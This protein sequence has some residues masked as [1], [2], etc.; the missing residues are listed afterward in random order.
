MK[1]RA[2]PE[3]YHRAIV[4]IWAILTAPRRAPGTLSS[5]CKLH[6][7]STT[8]PAALRRSGLISGSRND[9]RWMGTAGVPSI[10]TCREIMQRTLSDMADRQPPVAVPPTP[11]SEPVAPPGPKPVQL[12]LD[13]DAD[14]R[15]QVASLTAAV[16]ALIQQQVAA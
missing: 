2:T 7:V 3:Q 15:E 5:I 14:L 13:A 12:A 10:S 11:V 8:L 4:H 1:R 9:A 16:S 6:G